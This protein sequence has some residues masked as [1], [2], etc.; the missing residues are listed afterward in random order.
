ML[1]DDF[2]HV[3]DAVLAARSWRHEARCWR[4]VGGPG[5]LARCVGDNA[6]YFHRYG[7]PAAIWAPFPEL[8]DRQRA[9]E[10]LR[11][12]SRCGIFCEALP[13]GWDAPVEVIIW[14]KLR[15][16]LCDECAPTQRTTIC[17]GTRAALVLVQTASRSIF[18]PVPGASSAHR[19]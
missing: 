12:A 11:L 18:C 13:E 19:P 4:V 14:R 15:A 2:E 1:S 16:G 8:V 9:V 7:S 17:I 5:L 6:T 3:D 10:M